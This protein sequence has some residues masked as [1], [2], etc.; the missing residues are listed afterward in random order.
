MSF[1][2]GCNSAYGRDIVLSEA[3][4]WFHADAIGALRQRITILPPGI[5]LA[6]L[7]PLRPR[8]HSRKIKIIVNHRLLK[9][10]GVRSLLTRVFPQLWA[11]RRDFSVTVT[12]PSCVRLPRNITEA[13]WIILKTLP[14]HEYAKL[15]QEMDIVVSPHRATHWSISTV[16]AVCAGC[17]P[18]MNVESFFP[19]MFEPV[20]GALPKNFRRMSTI[21]GSIIGVTSLDGCTISWTTSNLNARLSGRSAGRC[22]VSMTGTG[23]STRGWTCST[24]RKALFQSWRIAILR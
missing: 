7:G 21:G 23:G 22:A 4:R 3:R 24:A 1:A 17:V 2:V 5:D 9:Y 16:E 13:P 12:N 18:L 20:L 11:E 6:E 10:T 19:E 15:L 14:R 8:K